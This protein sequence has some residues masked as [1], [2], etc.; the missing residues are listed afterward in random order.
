LHWECCTVHTAVRELQN[1]GAKIHG[2][3]VDG[4]FYSG[5]ESEV[6]TFI[7]TMYHPDDQPI[8]ARKT[9]FWQT[10]P[11]NPQRFDDHERVTKML[12][13]EAARILHLQKS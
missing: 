1:V 9:G 13:R 11:R 5:A 7:D 10:C 2:V 3:C 12:R 4:I 8:Y 6:D